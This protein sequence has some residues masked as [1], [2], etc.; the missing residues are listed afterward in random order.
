MSAL[1]RLLLR[2]TR[3]LPVREIRISNRRY[4]ERHW[5]GQ[6]GPITCY[7]HR[8]LGGDG[9]RNVH[10][11]P[12]GWAVGIPLT[13]GYDEERVI[14][15]CHRE[16]WRS[17]T[18]RVRPWKWNWLFAGTFHRVARTL[19]DT[20][21]LFI[22]GPRIKGW[23]FLARRWPMATPI[24]EPVVEYSQPYCTEASIDWQHSARPA[25]AL[26]AENKEP[27]Q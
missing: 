2:L 20:W 16:G 9:E 1:N 5:V 19:P 15:L 21:T 8:Y 18:V 7:L 4:M 26:R 17:R 6:I 23:G 27:V 14:G 12:W 11:H 3:D 22:H 25:W 10:D 13:G 24:G